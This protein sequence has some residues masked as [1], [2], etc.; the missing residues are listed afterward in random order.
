MECRRDGRSDD[1]WNFHTACIEIRQ[2]LKQVKAGQ[3]KAPMP[4]VVRY[5]QEQRQKDL[6]RSLADLF[7]EGKLGSI[8]LQRQFGDGRMKT[9]RV[10]VL[11]LRRALQQANPVTWGNVQANEFWNFIVTWMEQDNGRW[12]KFESQFKKCRNAQ[13]GLL[14]LTLTGYETQEEEEWRKNQEWHAGEDARRA[15]AMKEKEEKERGI[16]LAAEKGVKLICENERVFRK[17]GRYTNT[18]T[19]SC[20]NLSTLPDKKFY[21]LT[22]VRDFLLKGSA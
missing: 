17:C 2:W 10:S 21:L 15:E 22:D 5:H 11:A 9:K 6:R 18:I 3:F 20:Y 4:S 14:V 13:Q 8:T 7:K 1:E 19:N 16:A 12:I